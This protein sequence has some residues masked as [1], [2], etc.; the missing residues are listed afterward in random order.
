MDIVFLGLIVFLF[1]LAIFDLSVG[2]SNDA[3]NFLNSAL[4]SKAAKFKTILIIAG[5]GVFLGAVMSN[6]MMDI[7]RHGIFRPSHFSFFDVIC[8]FMAVMV[9]DIILLDVFNSLGMPTS[10]TVSM[11]FELL[12]A[13][14]AVSLLKMMEG[15]ANLGLN[16]LINTEKA[17]SVILGIFLSIA[18]AFVFGTIVQFITRCLFTM[19]YR[20]T[21]P[22]F[23][24]VYSGLAITIII[25]FMLFKG[26]KSS[27]IMTPDAVHWLDVNAIWVLGCAFV[28]LT[29]LMRLISY[30]K[31]DV[32]RIVVLSGT[33]ALAMAF[34]G[35][36]LV[37]FIGVPLAALSSWQDFAASGSSDAT[38]YMMHS[39]NES[40]TTPFYFLLG[41]GVIM[42]VA[43]ATSKKAQNVS[44]TEIGLG[45]KGGFEDEMFGS[46]A[47][48][49]KI[50]R[51]TIKLSKSI[52]SHTPASVRRWI[53]SRFETPESANK[54]GAAYDMLRAS[55]NLML[56]ALLI[57]GGT[58]LKLPL[59]TTFVTFMVAMGTSLADRAW[60]R[61]SAVFRITGVISVIGGWFITAGVAF[62]AAALLVTVMHYGGSFVM[63]LAGLVAIV[64]LICSNRRFKKKVAEENGDVMFRAI[65]NTEDSREGWN[66]L[67][68]YIADCQIN[69]I[70]Y[71]ADTYRSLCDGLI[72]DRVKE[73]HRASTSLDKCKQ[74]LK[75]RRRRLTLC[76]RHVNGNIL[77]EKST[78]FHMSN[79]MCQSIMYSL[80]RID[81]VTTE[82]VDNNFQPLDGAMRAQ[83][84]A[85]EAGVLEYLERAAEVIGN[86]A[87]GKPVIE[88]RREIDGF[89]DQL[90]T[91]I[92]GVYSNLHIGDTQNMSVAYVYLN[93]L[94]ETQE[95]MSSL[96]RLL[97]SAHKLQTAPSTEPSHISANRNA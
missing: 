74:Q 34:A 75:N 48:S 23:R 70:R 27:S 79:N 13:A 5:I 97:R 35:N 8:I 37:N 44:K 1:L 18:I 90:S 93:L 32:L 9:I 29:L 26:L 40:A 22:W 91:Y 94:Q 96:R 65:L 20:K 36:D 55:V 21:S 38:T 95:G 88:L 33:F 12:G 66:L 58:Q 3:V 67:N 2:V 4:G 24:S 72:N 28:V 31:F 77:L 80:K 82:H 19:N 62:V 81:E 11:V 87:H 71:A 60:G 51:N 84:E 7:A 39:L 6:G 63:V 30:F 50:V 17:F 43:L 25:W 86:G 68:R 64:L 56:A 73:L 85:V 16:D 52:V 57:A 41:A 42:V 54:S 78:W 76:L 45:A 83:C 92:H 47:I 61:E 14:F 69:F 46:S 15:S 53:D 59:S 49:R 10:T 89:K